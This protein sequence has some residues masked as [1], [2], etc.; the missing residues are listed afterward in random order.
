MD[1]QTNS[2]DED[3]LRSEVV[4]LLLNGWHQDQYKPHILGLCKFVQDF[5]VTGMHK[6]KLLKLDLTFL[7]K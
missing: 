2:N 6:L 1:I 5:E 7:Q 4:N 3:T